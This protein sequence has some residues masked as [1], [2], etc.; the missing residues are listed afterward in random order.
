MP[1]LDLEVV[2]VKGT[3]I[4]IIVQSSKKIQDCPF[5]LGELVLAGEKHDSG[6]VF[7]RALQVVEDGVRSDVRENLPN[8]RDEHDIEWRLFHFISYRGDQVVFRVKNTL[9]QFLEFV[10]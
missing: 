1:P 7:R 4:F 9:E 8:T 6:F 2:D 5:F 10:F 3:V